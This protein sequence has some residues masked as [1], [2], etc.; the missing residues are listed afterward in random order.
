MMQIE[1]DEHGTLYKL[2]MPLF[3]EDV[4]D[5]QLNEEALLAVYG[6]AL[7]EGFGKKPEAEPP[8]VTDSQPDVTASQK[9]FID[10]CESSDGSGY[11]E[12]PP[13]YLEYDGSEAI[14]SSN[15]GSDDSNELD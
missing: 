2:N 8:L 13:G 1:G 14:D 7:D 4:L 9:A 12:P 10:L 6:S 15:S 3:D 5:T 11:D